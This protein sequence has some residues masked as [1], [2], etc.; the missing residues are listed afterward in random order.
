MDDVTKKVLI[1]TGPTATGKTDLALFLAKRFNGELISADSRQVYTGLDLGTGKYP[2][3]Y[4]TI[5]KQPRQWLI[6]DILVHLYDV[7]SPKDQYTAY[8]FLSDAKRCID[9][10]HRLGKLPIVVGGTGLYLKALVSGLRR[11]D[12]VK[13]NLRKQLENLS[14]IELQ[15]KVQE[16]SPT[17]WNELN[18]SDNKNMRRLIRIVEQVGADATGIEEGIKGNCDL[19]TIGVSAPRE[20]LY[21]RVNTRA[22]K[23]VN[24]GMIGEARALLH[25]GLTLNRMRELGLEYRILADC[26]E[27]A[28]AEEEFLP[29]LQ[30]KI[31]QFVKRQLTWFKKEIDIE[32]FKATD[33]NLYIKVEKRV[34]VWYY[35]H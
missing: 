21:D 3:S 20:I 24:E 10:I 5:E 33:T 18:D 8:Q 34:A 17:R 12:E 28:I 6:D 1:I 7:A 27:G 19:L 9:K 15:H 30:T 11:T 13:L 32:W 16:I 25:G 4:Q 2:G 29:L 14:L 26:L 35:S 22:V 23:R 31:R